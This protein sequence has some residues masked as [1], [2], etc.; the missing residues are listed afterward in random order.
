MFL[1][2]PAARP[3][4]AKTPFLL[5][6][7]GALLLAFPGPGAAYPHTG[8]ELAFSG[9]RASLRLPS[10]Q[11]DNPPPQDDE[12]DVGEYKNPKRLPWSYKL[13]LRRNPQVEKVIWHWE[14]SGQSS[15][16][17]R[18]V[19]FLKSGEQEAYRYRSESDMNRA[20][21]RYGMLPWPAPPLARYDAPPETPVIKE[22]PIK[23]K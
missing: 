1:Q 3:C 22:K 6:L 23:Q 17:V 16:P 15:K 4:R 19:V 5:A 20:K 11:Q 13:F 14:Q 12:F 18:V 7:A 8:R 2:M 9:L 21:R 10:L